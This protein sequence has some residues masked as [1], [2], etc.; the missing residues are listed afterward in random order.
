[1]CCCLIVC[2]CW[3]RYFDTRVLESLL[4]VLTAPQQQAFT[5]VASRWCWLDRAGQLQA[6]EAQQSQADVWPQNF[7]LSPSQQNALVEAG[8]G[9]A[10]VEQM[11]TLAPDLCQNKARAEL[12]VLTTGCLTK[13]GKLHIE[14]IRTQ[15][16]YCLIALQLGTKFDLEPV[17]ADA[18]ERVA[19]KQCTF[20][21]ALNEMGV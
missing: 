9:D 19:K 12:H 15:T 5:G 1:M 18:L 20:A 10:L 16:L 8:E 14:D 6:L 7:E 11:V 3:L 21:E 17:W 13:F 4:R 2:P